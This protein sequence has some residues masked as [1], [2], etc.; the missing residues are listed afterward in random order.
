MIADENLRHRAATA[1]ALHFRALLRRR[2]HVDLLEGNALAFEQ[3]AGPTAVGTPARG[4]HRDRGS[5]HRQAL[6]TGRFSARQPA[7]P[8][9]REKALVNPWVLS[10]RTAAADSDPDSSITTTGF[11]LKR[12]KLSPAVR[13][14]SE[15]SCLA[16]F[17]WPS[18]NSSGLRM[19]STSAP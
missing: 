11:S 19:S 5:R 4:V 7:N 15:G 18:A 3:R 16:P 8:P 14:L 2:F 12:L 17:T 9:R 1:A 13:I 6:E 10:W